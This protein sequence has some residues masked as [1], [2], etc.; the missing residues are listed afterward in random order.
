[1]A[2]WLPVV[3]TGLDA[4]L[5][6]GDARAESAMRLGL[7]CVNHCLAR[8]ETAIEQYVAARDLARRTGW[9][10]VEDAILANLGIAYAEGGDC[11]AAGGA[12]RPAPA[13]PNNPGRTPL[14]PPQPGR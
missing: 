1:A 10:E 7:A 3:H 4:A 9:T 6:M 14:H 8:R 12:F 2:E 11:D 13:P 5:R